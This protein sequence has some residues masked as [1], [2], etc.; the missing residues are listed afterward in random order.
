MFYRRSLSLLTSVGFAALLYGGSPALA[1]TSPPLGVAGSFSVL[2]G[3]A[4]TNTGT[5]HIK[6]HADPHGTVQ[7]PPD[8]RSRLAPARSPA[9]RSGVP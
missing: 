2:A 3:S 4:V 5:T 1:A 9:R 7:R 6:D 8:D